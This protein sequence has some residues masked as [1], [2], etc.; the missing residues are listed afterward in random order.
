[1]DDA[2]ISTCT[3]HMCLPHTRSYAD[4]VPMSLVK[5]RL[6]SYKSAEDVTNFIVKRNLLYHCREKIFPFRLQ[7]N[8]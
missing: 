6:C 4:N 7:A 2:F 3:R 5:T 1:M 8:F